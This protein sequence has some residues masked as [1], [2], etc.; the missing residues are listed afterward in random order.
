M[1]PGGGG[2][3]RQRGRHASPSRRAQDH[4]RD[5]ER[6]EA[7]EELRA[8]GF[9]F[10]STLTAPSCFEAASWRLG[11]PASTLRASHRRARRAL[12]RGDVIGF[13]GDGLPSSLAQNERMTPD[14]APRATPRERVL[15]VRVRRHEA[16]AI[17]LLALEL[18]ETMSHVVRRAVMRLLDEHRGGV[19]ELSAR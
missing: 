6:F 3:A 17:R 4:A 13:M 12:A 7:V 2:A 10:R 16:E 1:E 14:D 18:D 5:L 9:S 19:P 15:T 8:E 11:V